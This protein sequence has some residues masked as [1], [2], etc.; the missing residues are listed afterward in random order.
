[1]DLLEYLKSFVTS[2]E[3]LNAKNILLDF[4]ERFILFVKPN[5]VSFICLK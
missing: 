5:D 2:N 3:E 1:M 4:K